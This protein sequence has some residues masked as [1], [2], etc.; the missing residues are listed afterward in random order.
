M[1]AS[2][3][4]LL[5]GAWHASWC[6]KYVTPLLQQAGHTVIEHDFIGHGKNQ[7]DFSKINLKFYIKELSQLILDQSQPIILVA[8]S[9]AGVIASQ[10]AENIPDKIKK[11]IYLAAFVP[12]NNSS[13]ILEST[14]SNLNIKPAL[15][16]NVQK[17]EMVLDSSNLERVRSIFYNRCSDADLQLA[18]ERLQPEPL[19][20]MSQIIKISQNGFGVVDKKYIACVD[21]FAID[22]DNQMR[23]AN[24]A[25]I[26]NVIKLY[27]DH[28]PFFSAPGELVEAILLKLNF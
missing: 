10:V 20:P 8:H 2:T 14:Y 5:H 15:K 3:Y 9:F 16:A 28:S 4:I 22:I 7:Y 24:N 6:W 1:N 19:L 12:K 26:Q 27:A 11:I 25:N 21:D 13:L 23:M 18:L 17:N